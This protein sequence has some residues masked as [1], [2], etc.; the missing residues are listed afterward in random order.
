M[1]HLIIC[2]EYPPVPTSPGGI[3]TYVFHLAQLLAEAGETVHVI[4]QLWQG[5]PLKIEK[6]CQGKLIIH[7]VPS[8]EKKSLW[9][10]NFGSQKRA[11]EL[12][13]LLQSPFPPQCFSWQASLLAEE[14]VEQE[15]IDIIESQEY[16]SPLYYF[17]LRRALGFGPKKYPPCLIHLH[18][19]TEFIALHNQWDIN[20]SFFQT[21]KRLEA[22]SIATADALLCP[23]QF[24]ARQAEARYQ[25][26]TGSIK[27]I[28][29]PLGDSPFLERDQETWNNGTICYIGRLEERKGI[30]E[31]LEAAVA[32]APKYPNAQ[33]EFIG[34]NCLGSDRINGDEF[35]KQRIPADLSPRFHFRGQQKRSQLP[36]FLQ[37]ARIAV[38]PSRWENFPNTCVE[39]MCSGLPVIASR[40][41]GMVE[42]IEDNQTGWLVKESGS[43]GLSEALERALQTPPDQLRAMGDRACVSIRQLCDNQKIVEEQIAFRQEIVNRGAKQSFSVPPNLPWIEN[44]LASPPVRP[45][46]LDPS[47]QG[48]AVVI[49]CFRDPHLLG[50]CWQSLQKQSQKPAAVVIVA[51][52][53]TDNSISPVLEQYK[54][55]FTVEQ[56]DED[57]ATAHNKAIKAV[58]SSGCK[59]LGFAFLNAGDRLEADFITHCESVLQHC[60][61]VGLISSWTQYLGTRDKFWLKPCPSFPYQW[62][63]NEASP[64]SV[65]RAQALYQVGSFRVGMAESFEFWD[66]VNGVMALGWV[67]VTLP[68]ILGTSL[69]LWQMSRLNASHSD[70][71]AYE[72]ILTRFPILVERDVSDLILIARSDKIW[73]RPLLLFGEDNLYRLKI[74]LC[75]SQG[76]SWYLLTKFFNIS[77]DVLAKLKRK[78]E[79]KLKKSS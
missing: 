50:K 56:G 79:Q 78:V 58:L 18:S 40:Q 25:L 51:K 37:Q 44:S 14:L 67:A 49:T 24:F 66:L 3:G 15:N 69:R 20:Y 46:R 43:E 38:V 17:Q 41:G 54:Q 68:E 13:A 4:S 33:F 47:E 9:H 34:A 16:Q 11:R 60:P 30:L 22:Y 10:D 39:A 27:T 32:I 64:L 6:K 28:P 1:K 65:V 75:Y 45:H 57:L 61:E 77:W 72:K 8:L 26:E 73:S 63:L 62:L 21:A 59:P 74:I 42:M 36:Q 53:L 76:L 12:E 71:V 48:I 2:S 55:C 31:W 23:S 52:K 19:P 5:A 7:R 29:L 35:L 70:S